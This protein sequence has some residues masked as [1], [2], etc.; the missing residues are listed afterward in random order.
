MTESDQIQ[1]IKDNYLKIP[2][3]TMA[4]VIGRS[5]SFVQGRMKK[6]GLVVPAMIVA[7]RKTESRFK[8][9]QESF[10]KGLKQQD[11]MTQDAIKKSS[12]TRFKKG[13]S[14]QNTKYN[15]HISVRTSKGY[16]YK[17][18]RVA[19]GNYE[20]LH[21]HVWEAQ[22]GPIH[23]NKN[24]QFRDG[25]TLNCDIANL[26]L[27]DRS[28]QAQI[29]KRGGKALPPEVQELVLVVNNLNKKINEK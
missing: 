27:I 6:M 22:H 28:E 29:N 2:V 19:K 7:K 21:R 14:P 11:F 24:V 1:F 5:G 23:K 13:Q 20:L 3:K 9:G 26:Y 12:K 18:I 10:N 17:W 4:R 8:K 15:R 25:D 16:D